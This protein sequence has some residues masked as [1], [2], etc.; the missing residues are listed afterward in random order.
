[1]PRCRNRCG[2]FCPG[3]AA[4]AKGDSRPTRCAFWTAKRTNVLSWQRTRPNQLITCARRA[5]CIHREVRVQAGFERVTR[6]Q[7]PAERVDRLHV[8]PVEDGE[9]RSG[10]QPVR[11]DVGRLNGGLVAEH[12]LSARNLRESLHDACFHLGGG[13]FREGD[14]HHALEHALCHRAQRRRSAICRQLP[15]RCFPTRTETPGQCARDEHRR[16]AGSRAGLEHHRYT[17]DRLRSA[18]S[19]EI[20]LAVAHRG[21]A[22]QDSPSLRA[23]SSCPNANAA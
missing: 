15:L 14:R 16:L 5:A 7:P 9:Q 1:M 11:C 18:P 6:E 8:E 23:S 10:S 2:R 21:L 12:R 3:S 19:R 17:E 4:T 20:L 13:S 22:A